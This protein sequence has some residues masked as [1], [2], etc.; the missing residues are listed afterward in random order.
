MK[1]LVEVSLGELVDKI[2]ILR[3]KMERIKDA[4]KVAA[5][6]KEEAVLVASLNS[7]NLA[8]ID[9]HLGALQAINGKL[10]QIE[11]DIRVQEK[12]RKFDDQFIELARSVY[13]VNDERFRAKDA[14]NQAYGSEL[15]EVKSYEDYS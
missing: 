7:L 13:K 9:A 4:T 15:E 12:N 11:D 8:G 2:S 3:L 1:I 14:V 6:T 5:A 10:W